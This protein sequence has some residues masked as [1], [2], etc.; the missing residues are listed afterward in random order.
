ME[1]NP[2]KVFVQLFGEGDTPA[3]RETLARQTREHP[4][5]HLRPHHRAAEARS[6]RRTAQVLDDYLDTIREIERRAREVEARA[7]SRA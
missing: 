6:A 5:P 1:F 3:E 2:R 4:R 7:T